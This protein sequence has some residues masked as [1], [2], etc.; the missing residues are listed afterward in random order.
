MLIKKMITRKNYDTPMNGLIRYIKEHGIPDPVGSQLIFAK[1][2]N[3]RE[4]FQQPTC[5][6]DQKE[7]NKLCY[8]SCSNTMYFDITIPGF[9][10]YITGYGLMSHSKDDEAPRTWNL[11]CQHDGSLIDYVEYDDSLCPSSTYSTICGKY[12][13]K[14]Y[15]AKNPM[16]CNSIRFTQIG[17]SSVKHN[18]ISLA[19]FE[20]FGT[21][22]TIS[23]HLCSSLNQYHI[24]AALLSF[25]ALYIY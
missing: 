12:D 2:Y 3:I 10:I 19:G 21:M 15:I 13:K 6:I 23:F 9:E 16:K 5:L 4:G 14:G 8:A 1:G 7:D 25:L 11:T 20:L 22:S 18:C 17:N 24:S